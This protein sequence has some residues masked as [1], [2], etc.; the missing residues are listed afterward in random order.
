MATHDSSRREALKLMGLGAVAFAFSDSNLNPSPRHKAKIG[1]QL[2]TVRKAIERD[3]EGTLKKV[4]D[5][6][7][8]RN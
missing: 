7:L 3:F 4:A 1:L 5:I 2:Y 6:G 8:R